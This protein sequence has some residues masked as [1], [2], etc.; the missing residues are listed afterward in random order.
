MSAESCSYYANV[1]ELPDFSVKKGD[2]FV[3]CDAGG[4]TVVRLFQP[5]ELASGGPN[6]WQDLTTYRV[7]ETSPLLRVDE[8]TVGSGELCGSVYLNRRFEDFVRERL[9]TYLDKLTK[10][11]SMEA[12]DG[13]RIPRLAIRSWTNMIIDTAG[14]R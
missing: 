9:A 4:G 12:I 5:L 8:V 14:L 6:M 10:S 1:D 2:V 11:Q 3:T 7:F 13:V